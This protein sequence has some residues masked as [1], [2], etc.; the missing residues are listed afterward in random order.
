MQRLISLSAGTS[1]LFRAVGVNHL[2]NNRLSLEKENASYATSNV[3]F[4]R[5]LSSKNKESK[6]GNNLNTHADLY[7]PSTTKEETHIPDELKHH[8]QPTDTIN[9]GVNT[10]K[11]S[12]GKVWS[13]TNPDSVHVA[14]LNRVNSTQF[15]PKTDKNGGKPHETTV[16][17]TQGELNIADPSTTH[18]LQPEVTPAQLAEAAAASAFETDAPAK[19]A[20]TP[21]AVF[22]PKISSSEVYSSPSSPTA[23]FEGAK[24]SSTQS[25]SV[26]YEASNRPRVF[27][28]QDTSAATKK[29]PKGNPFNSNE[30]EKPS[31]KK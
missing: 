16:Y 13:A 31:Q 1:R 6:D 10:F 21:E 7:K 9:T 18:K 26:K 23:N 24:P 5:C 2:K 8:H 28:G 15:V 19:S 20:P 4:K 29:H 12:G 11:K 25:E 22:A 27:G 17:T 14:K 30:I 3:I